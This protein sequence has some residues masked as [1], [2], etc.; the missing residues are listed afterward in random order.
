MSKKLTMSCGEQSIKEVV[1]NLEGAKKMLLEWAHFVAGTYVPLWNFENHGEKPRKGVGWGWMRKGFVGGG[2]GW[3]RLS[4]QCLCREGIMYNWK[5]LQPVELRALFAMWLWSK[6]APPI[7]RLHRVLLSLEGQRTVLW[8]FRSLWEIYEGSG[9]VVR[10][11]LFSDES[12]IWT[13]GLTM[14]VRCS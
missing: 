5:H 8:F 10:N 11:R 3:V 4:V 13:C 2:G 12:L 9:R 1:S 7:M 6:T 14:Q